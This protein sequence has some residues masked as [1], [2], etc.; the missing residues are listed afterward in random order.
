VPETPVAEPSVAAVTAAMVRSGIVTPKE[1]VTPLD[2]CSWVRHVTIPPGCTLPV[3]AEFTKTW[4]LKHFASGGEYDFDVL[5]LV[6]K[7]NG[8][9]GA[10]VNK[11]VTIKRDEVQEEGEVEVTIEGLKVPDQPGEE[12]VEHWRFEDD[13]GVAYGQPL[14]LR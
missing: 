2:I 8:E 6:H 11:V 5:R 3:G 14:R 4:K 1:P 10:A 7:S 12:I 13:K 9:L